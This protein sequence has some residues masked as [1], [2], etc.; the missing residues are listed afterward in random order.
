[1]IIS[2][3]NYLEAANEEILGGGRRKRGD[4]NADIKV[5]K[6][7]KIFVDV[8][9]TYDKAIFGF[10]NV[11]GNLATAEA[12]ADATGYDTFTETFT[13]TDVNPYGSESYS[14]SVSGTR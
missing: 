12:G 1:M 11:H 10:V 3:L 8:F 14:G 4:I 2:D 7:V 13:F 6:E 5:K 9:E